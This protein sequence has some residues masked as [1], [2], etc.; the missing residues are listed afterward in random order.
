M[1]DDVRTTERAWRASGSVDDHARHLAALVRAGR[2]SFAR[3]RLAARLGHAAA[4]VASGIVALDGR[5]LVPVPI[6][7]LER[8]R[9]AREVRLRLQD[10]LHDAEPPASLVAA[11]ALHD[12]APIVG[13]ESSALVAL[14]RAWLASGDASE[15][16]RALPEARR[17]LDIPR[18]PSTLEDT[19]FARHLGVLAQA[20]LDAGPSWPETV[21]WAGMELLVEL[22]RRRTVSATP[23]A[24][25]E[26]ARTALLAWALGEAA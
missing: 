12:L 26:T 14:V 7:A 6:D 17:R 24:Q 1:D 3:L 18:P 4:G 16:A 2:L 9:G 25:W 22:T 10:V 15:L 23:E 21:G 8:R 5:P 13:P 20:A 19:S 11:L